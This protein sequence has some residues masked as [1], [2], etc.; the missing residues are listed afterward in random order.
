MK[1]FVLCL[2]HL[3]TDLEKKLP[4]G[5]ADIVMKSYRDRDQTWQQLTLVSDFCVSL[6]ARLI[7]KLTHMR[8]S[9]YFQR[10]PSQYEDIN[11]STSSPQL[12]ESLRKLF[13]ASFEKNNRQIH[14]ET[15]TKNWRD[16]NE[17]SSR[18]T[19][20]IKVLFNFKKNMTEIYL[21]CIQKKLLLKVII[22]LFLRNFIHPR[23]FSSMF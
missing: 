7:H 6:C 10:L 22:L 3:L 4:V 23:Y 16:S 9:R 20:K 19:V 12:I 14:T 5:L 21:Y 2:T 1:W 8:R 13:P 17:I 15:E 18:Q 11:I